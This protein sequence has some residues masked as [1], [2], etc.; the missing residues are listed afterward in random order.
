MTDEQRAD[1]LEALIAAL[2][3]GEDIGLACASGAEVIAPGGGNVV[4]LSE[5]ARRNLAEAWARARE[6]EPEDEGHG[7]RTW[8]IRRDM[9]A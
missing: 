7:T 8:R 4:E 6:L 1:A 9:G 2:L 5:G 3:F